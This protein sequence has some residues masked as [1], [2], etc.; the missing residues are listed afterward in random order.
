MLKAHYSGVAGLIRNYSEFTLI[1]WTTA[2]S[3]PHNDGTV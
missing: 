2:F 1:S 3:H